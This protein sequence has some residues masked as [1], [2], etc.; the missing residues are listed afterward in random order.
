MSKIWDAL[1]KAEQDKNQSA[2][3][4]GPKTQDPAPERRSTKCVL[5]NALVSVY[6]YGDTRNPFY[7]QSEAVSVSSGGGV[8]ILATSVNPGQILLLTNEAS[9]KEEKC[10]VREVSVDPC[11]ARVVFEF[12]RPDADFWDSTQL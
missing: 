1:R 9:L 6:G 4:S 7:E 3:V 5:A 10:V 8:M 12:L 11:G 2:G